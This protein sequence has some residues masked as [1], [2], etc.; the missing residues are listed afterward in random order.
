ML[1]TQIVRPLVNAYQRI[2]HFGRIRLRQKRLY[3]TENFYYKILAY[4]TIMRFT[5]MT[6]LIPSY[7]VSRRKETVLTATSDINSYWGVLLP[8]AEIVRR[9]LWGF[10]FV[11]RETIRLME[12][13]SMYSVEVADEESDEDDEGS[14]YNAR[15]QLVPTWLDNQQQVAHNAATSRAKQRAECLQRLFVLELYAWAGA[16]VVL[17]CWAAS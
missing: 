5:W 1:Q 13:D 6:C 16:F 14:K 2:P 15:S 8:I 10:L 12:A 7:H 17:G 11:E 9:T 4:N 3:K